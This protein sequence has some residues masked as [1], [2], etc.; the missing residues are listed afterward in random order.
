MLTRAENIAELGGVS[1]AYEALKRR[2]EEG[3]TSRDTIDGFTPE[4]RFFRSVGQ[5]WRNNI[6]DEELRRRL[7]IDPHSSAKFRVIGPLVNL[8]EFWAAFRI[9]RGSAMRRPEERRVEIWQ[10]ILSTGPRIQT[11][12]LVHTDRRG[13]PRQ[14]WCH[15]FP[16][17]KEVQELR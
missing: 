11:G 8:P 16:A 1:I 5:I 17:S 10:R 12:L 7:T 14:H 6:C 13:R 9:P 2:L 15:P 3:R 4:Q